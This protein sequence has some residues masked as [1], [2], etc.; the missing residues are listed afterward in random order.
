MKQVQQDWKTSISA[1][2]N[3]LFDFN[4]G[5]K[6]LVS[7]VYSVVTVSLTL[8]EL[9]HEKL[10]FAYLNNKGVDQPASLFFTSM[11]V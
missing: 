8:Y 5:T 3:R 9:C 7:L 4:I 2:V 10:V 11:I 6:S 1:Y